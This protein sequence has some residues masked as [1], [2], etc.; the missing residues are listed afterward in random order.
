M[1]SAVLLQMHALAITIQVAPPAPLEQFGGRLPVQVYASPPGSWPDY[2]RFVEAGKITQMPP[3]VQVVLHRPLDE[4]FSSVIGSFLSATDI[5]AASPQMSEQL[6][7]LQEWLA[8][9]LEKLQA[10]ALTFRCGNFALFFDAKARLQGTAS[11]PF[12]TA[13]HQGGGSSGLLDKTTSVV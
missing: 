13:V 11:A 2:E 12:K 6:I 5:E 9:D 8:R 7:A 1:G 4:N 10:I 3:R